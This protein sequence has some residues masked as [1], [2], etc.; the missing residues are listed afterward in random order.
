LP[1]NP[2]RDIYGLDRR[3]SFN[4]EMDDMLWDNADEGDMEDVNEEILDTFGRT[5]SS[6]EALARMKAKQPTAL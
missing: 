5:V 6:I 3:L 4:I 1:T 2:N